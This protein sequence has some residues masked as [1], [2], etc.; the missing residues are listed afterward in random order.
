[1]QTIPYTFYVYNIVS[2]SEEEEERER[3]SNSISF[4]SLSG[5]ER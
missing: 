4:V 1:M 3:K 5:G 2:I